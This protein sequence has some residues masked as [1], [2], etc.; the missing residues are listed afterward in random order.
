[1]TRALLLL[2]LVIGACAPTVEPVPAPPSV[3]IASPSATRSASPLAPTPTPITTT[4]VNP[5]ANPFPSLP[6]FALP[7]AI[8]ADPAAGTIV[9]NDRAGSWRY[10]GTRGALAP[11]LAAAN[12]EALD[13]HVV[14]TQ[15]FV[16]GYDAGLF[17]ARIA[18]FL[19]TLPQETA[20]SDSLSVSADGRRVAYVT[21][22][23]GLRIAFQQQL[24]NVDGR[25]LA[26]DRL[27][28]STLIAPT[29]RVIAATGPSLADLSPPGS[30]PFDRTAGVPRDV[31]LV[32]IEIG[33]ARQ[34]YCTFDPCP[35]PLRPGGHTL[36]LLS[37]S[38]DERY[39]LAREPSVASG[40]DFDG[41]SLFILD[42]QTGAL[43]DLGVGQSFFSWR[44]W[45]GPHALA[46][47]IGLGH[48]QA[49]RLRV[50]SAE[51]GVRDVTDAA[52]VAVSPS[53]GVIDRLVY[54]VLDGHL[55]T[56]D[57]DTN[58]IRRLPG[59]AAWIEDAVRV[60]DDGTDLLVL[61]RRVADGQL[62]LW[63]MSRDASA[64]HALVRYSPPLSPEDAAR[65]GTDRFAHTFDRLVW[66]R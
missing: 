36:Q 9:F 65:Y 53:F 49:K 14:T 6:F 58:A 23:K 35:A 33:A 34:I 5:T 21:P 60:S 32:D 2:V 17:D 48:E 13:R 4:P 37:W 57:P 45:I 30:L 54:F 16:A 64:M 31:W 59:D 11:L 39:L 10:D 47:V 12:I 43:T 42:P 51:A 50:W 66:S 25:A 61:R 7:S 40:A 15:P 44:T 8:A 20:K 22:Q 55:A 63:R 1:M 38:P 3:T 46:F 56:F 27:F 28:N 62:E 29:G 41:T 24:G 26:R 52:G 18:A 19:R